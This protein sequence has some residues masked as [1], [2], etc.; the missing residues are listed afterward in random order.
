[1][2]E[3]LNMVSS[4][5]NNNNAEFA[6]LLEETL[7]DN[8]LQEG[9]IV[10]GKIIDILQ[11][12]VLIDVGF[13]SEGFIGLDEFGA[14]AQDLK[15]GQEIEVFIDRIDDEMGTI[16]LSKERAQTVKAWEDIDKIFENDEII[17]GK[18]LK[19]V[20]GGLTVDVGI[21]AFLPTSQIDL[22]PPKNLDPYVGKKFQFKILK[23]NKKRGNVVLSRRALLENERDSIKQKTLENIEEGQI[24]TG[25]VK[26]ITDYGAFVDLGGIDGLL[27]VT[28]MS[29]GRV[30]N[31]SEICKV[32]DTLKVKV[33]KY[34]VE[35]ERVSL[36]LKQISKDPWEE[37]ES[38]FQIG[39]KIIGKIV[40]LTNYGAFVELAP[41]IEGLIH[42][43]E[44][45]WT[46]KI[47]HPSHVLKLH[48]N[49]ESVVL[50]VDADGRRI[51]LGLKQL[52]PNPWDILEDK[53][54]EGSRVHCSVKNVTDF[55]LFVGVPDCP[56]DGLIH[57]SDLSWTKKVSSPAEHYKAGDEIEAVVLK[58][59]KLNEKFSLGLKQ[60]TPD[61]WN[62]AS[63][64]YSQG[65]TVTGKVIKIADFG[66]FIEFE[67]GLEALIRTSELAK[68]R[69]SDPK[70]VCQVG[71]E[72][73]GKVVNLDIHDR[74]IAV[75]RK[76]LLEDE[77]ES[78][79]K[80][81][82]NKQSVKS[83]VKLGDL[84]K[85]DPKD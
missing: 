7:T 73:T 5:K 44:M 59:D 77:E 51:S 56:I 55:G 28:D 49:V 43:S 46:K 54:Q 48:D 47:A 69:V 25:V 10:K 3:N 80:N 1:M 63:A 42:I 16:E 38:K 84:M 24:V 14:Q 71:D 6:K 64:K 26:N 53:Y 18:V 23:L 31:P 22:R 12:I 78:H 81:Y 40:S 61:P 30:E 85:E 79:L 62:E 60:L 82:M 57:I 68:E 21:A 52:E 19:K 74:K 65:Q 75:S 34:D 35:R 36:G 70:E 45:S 27:H 41:G 11:K 39:Q 50:D 4:S 37:V 72:I 9:K 67:D 13:K 76:T 17:E 20:K 32:G 8:T 29:W 83:K 15:K 33:L 58:I 66:V 2:Q